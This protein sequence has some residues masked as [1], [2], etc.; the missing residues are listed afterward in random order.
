MTPQIN[1]DT[2]I[3]CDQLC[4][5]VFYP[6]TAYNMSFNWQIFTPAPAVQATRS[7]ASRED[8]DAPRWHIHRLTPLHGGSCWPG[9]DPASRWWSTPYSPKKARACARCW[10]WQEGGD[11]QQPIL[12]SWFG[13]GQGGSMMWWKNPS[14]V[15]CLL[16]M[17][18]G[19]IFLSFLKFLFF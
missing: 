15:T 12:T 13:Q 8:G 2:R 1:T 11:V 4:V 17:C 19:N 7:N 14:S 16:Q 5:Y 9:S 6:L 18:V 3:K 10:G